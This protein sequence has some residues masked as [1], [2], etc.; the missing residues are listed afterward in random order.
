MRKYK[1]LFITFE[2]GEKTGKTTQAD[3]L[4]DTLRDRGYSVV[5]TREP[6]A[7][8][9]VGRQIREILMNPQYK[10]SKAT[11]LFLF[12]ADRA[13]HYK[14]ILKPNLK[15]G[16][17]VICDRYVDSTLVYQGHVGGW[18][19][20]LLFRLHGAGTGMLM[21]DVTFI[22]NGTRHQPLDLQDSYERRGETYHTDVKNSYLHLSSTHHRYYVVNSDLPPNEVADIILVH[23]LR[24]LG[25]KHRGR[26]S[27]Q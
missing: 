13:Q 20:P 2:G 7:D 19:L 14:E 8:T 27:C 23:T 9:S 4:A 17:I 22:L 3:I 1:G 12:Q 25:T 21:P 24:K 11:E 5:V 6:G 18:S 10:L 15:A 26:S 16:K